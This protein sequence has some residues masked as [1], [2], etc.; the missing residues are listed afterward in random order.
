VAPAR[1][2]WRATLADLP[3]RLR[4][5][6]RPPRR[7]RPYV[8]YLRAVSAA[9]LSATAVV[10]FL[11][12]WGTV[13][14]SPWEYVL[15]AVFILL[16]ELMPIRIARNGNDDTVTVS[17]AFAFAALLT[18]GVGPAIAA[19]AGASVVFDLVNRSPLS[20]L[21]FNVGQYALSLAAAAALLSLLHEL[22][23]PAAA[24]PGLLPGIFAAAVLSFLVNTVL[25]GTAPALLNGAKVFPYLRKDLGFQV[26]TSGFLLAIS[27]VIVIAAEATLALVPVL[28]LPTLAIY[29]A[30]R[31]SLISEYH[32]SHDSLTGLPNRSL[33]HDRLEHDL[34]MARRERAAV[35]VM[36]LDLDDFK[37]V[38][39]TLGHLHGDL[40]LRA[41]GPRLR[42]VLRET[43]T[44]A[45]L[46]GDEFA[47]ILPGIAGLED[48]VVV[49]AKI[50]E[51]L[52]R[53]FPIADLWLDVRTSIGIACFP[54]DGEDVG[55]LLR[56]ADVALYKA[57]YSK[58]ACEA[59][60][61]EEDEHTRERLALA[62]QLRR[63]IATDELELRY[64]PKFTLPG[65]E[66]KD[67]E[68]LVRWRHPQLGLLAP[69]AFIP[70]AEQTGL[71]RPLTER[72]LDEALRQVR[73]WRDAGVEVRVSVNL[74]T[75]NLVDRGLAV[76]LRELFDK[77]SLDASA[78]QLEITESALIDEARR[79]TSALQELS[80]LGIRLAIDDFGTGY[81]SLT[82][83]KR[84]P[85]SEIKIDKSFVSNMRASR[86]DAV[87]V[88]STIELARNL[89]LDTT[90][91]GVEEESICRQLTA[92]GCD[93]A[94]GFLLGRPV[95]G[96]EVIKQADG[97]RFSRDTT[98]VPGEHR[99]ARA[100]GGPQLAAV[101]VAEEA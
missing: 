77:W 55:L 82:Y 99:A 39:D 8:W 64:Q 90:A 31:Q 78:L 100:A 88:R 40:L 10:I 85:V 36:I 3:S 62:A 69:D 26:L 28:F 46:G 87:I 83:L 54:E 17:T 12:D 60:S 80:S 73:C 43:D 76:T 20:R 15:L 70:L 79:A 34:A 18:F 21:T 84:L 35:G 23:Y 59:Y 48:A 14:T 56:H 81:S 74:S 42:E 63:G 66:L 44:L 32:A 13:A 30:G 37:D 38:N 95:R 33:L 9:G 53:P 97:R 68:A 16:G 72:V 47:V 65:G 101:K 19:Y 67:V 2:H 89:G 25:A 71:I 93:F 91:E 86:E 24:I 75:R 58:T 22:P 51:A 61:P 4:K 94:Q 49:A 52:E 92:W 7:R 27:P 5:P 29:L 11:A 1:R 98:L 45:R 57:K 41:I 96:A 6:R 50:I